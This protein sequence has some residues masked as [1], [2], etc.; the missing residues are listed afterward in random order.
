LLDRRDAQSFDALQT[1]LGGEVG[2]TVGTPGDADS[3]QLGS[4]RTGSAWSTIKVPIAA[5]VL[6]A[7]GGP[8][9]LSTAQQGLIGRAITASDNAAAD[10]LFA[11]LGPDD[12]QAAAATGEVLR[13]AGDATTR[14]S[15]KG[16]DGFSPYGQTEW[17]LEEQ[18]RFMALL[19]A[20]DC[21][22][23]PASSRYLLE[24]MAQ[25]VADQQWGL[26]SAGA[27]AARFKGGW[28]PGTDGRYLVRQMGVIEVDGEDVVVT[29]A[30]VA[31]DG[32]FA[33]GTAAATELARWVARN[34]DPGEAQAVKC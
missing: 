32:Q 23:D 5:G 14:V 3:E 6:E 20:G 22:A 25:I 31:P 16:R 17:S 30:V 21:L 18:H 4:L 15:A 2:I 1:R 24:L 8:K 9:A 7:A 12:E 34:V 28:G 29:L 19:A 27:G 11:S 13:E 10:A 26:G 33:T